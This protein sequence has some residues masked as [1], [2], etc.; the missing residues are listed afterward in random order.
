MSTFRTVETHMLELLVLL[1]EQRIPNL[2]EKCDN[3][4]GPEGIV[5]SEVSATEKD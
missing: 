3:M 5:L 4:A 2:K 1:I